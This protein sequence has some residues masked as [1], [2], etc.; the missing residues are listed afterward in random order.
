MEMV[1]QW[2]EYIELVSFILQYST[3][4]YTVYP[5]L[6]EPPLIELPALIELE[7]RSQRWFD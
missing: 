6:I 1:E 7:F 3:D 4:R 5:A 2:N